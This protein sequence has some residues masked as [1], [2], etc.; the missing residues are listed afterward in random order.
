[1]EKKSNIWKY[2]LCFILCCLFGGI[3]YGVFVSNVIRKSDNS[4]EDV[5]KVELSRY[6]ISAIIGYIVN[7]VLLVL[8]F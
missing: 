7:V 1:M 5:D 8:F 3:A 6:S 2:I 4:G